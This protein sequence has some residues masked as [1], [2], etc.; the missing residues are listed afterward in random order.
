MISNP[1]LHDFR[2]LRPQFSSPQETSFSW[3]PAAH[4]LADVAR[5]EPDLTERY[6]KILRRVGCSSTQIASRGH[7][8]ADFNHQNW[9]D[10]EIFDLGKSPAGMGTEGRTLAYAKFVQSAFDRFY[11]EDTVAPNDL[12]HVTCTGYLSPSPAQRLVVHK[13]WGDRTE[14]T[15]AYHMGCYAAFP[16]IRQAR[17]FLAASPHKKRVDLVHTELCGLHLNPADHAL[18]NFVIQTLF[19]DGYARYSMS[20]AL[21]AS[22]SAGLEVLSIREIMIPGTEEAMTWLCGDAG[23]K[24]TLSKDVPSLVAAHLPTFIQTVLSPLGLSLDAIRA[25]ARFAIH[26]GGPKI[27]D[28]VQ[29]SLGL[30][31]EQVQASREVLNAYGNMSSATLPHIWEKIVAKDSVPGGALVLSLAFGPGLTLCGALLRKVSGRAEAARG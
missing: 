26:P 23:M 31:A 10:M 24:M 14:V 30:R 11:A 21:P 27:L 17:G 16:G 7:E 9:S 29:Q 5:G 22:S 2:I 6:K 20:P 4:A 1:V 15:H 3:L 8:L 28:Q 25:E 13:G 19:A 18:E 12:I